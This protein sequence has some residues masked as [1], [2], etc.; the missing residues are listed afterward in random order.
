ME[1]LLA[2]SHIAGCIR[3][4]TASALP[5]LSLKYTFTFN[6]TNNNGDFEIRFL[7]HVIELSQDYVLVQIL[8][9]R[10]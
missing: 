2:E 1:V 4:V 10:N 7:V 9:R 6:F 8:N 3:A 5:D